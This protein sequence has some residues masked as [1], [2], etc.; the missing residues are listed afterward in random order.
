MSW[1]EVSPN[2]LWLLGGL[3][4]V[5][6]IGSV[7]RIGWFAAAPSKQARTRLASLQVWWVLTA[8]LAAAVLLGK[9]AAVLL[10]ALAS[11]LGLREFFRLTAKRTGPHVGQW[12]AYA[13]VPVAY[14]WVWLGW[15]E[16]LWI[17]VPAGFLLLVSAYAVSANKIRGFIVDVAVELWG[18]MLLVFCLSH[19]AL[20]FSLPESSNP[21]GHSG[22]WFLY[23][24]LLTES[25]DIAQALWGRQFGRH[26][27][28]PHVSPNK[29]W[30]GLL[31]GIA[32]TVV[33]ALLLAPWLTPLPWEWAAGAGLLIAVG[34][35]FGDITMSAVKRDVGVK[36]SGTLLPGMGGMLDRV[37]SL[38]F[39]APLFFYFVYFLRAS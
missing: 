19:A 37:D 36:D 14:W 18:V 24:V 39:T 25:N 11:W 38:T 15:R 22:G 5:L 23:L 20:L 12:L 17:S 28:T 31:L 30:E 8:L 27:V 35:F 10:L 34:G 4:G 32:T 7:V 3:L 26:H 6:T 29:T 13:M 9:T 21:R 2:V 1:P 33:L 16:M